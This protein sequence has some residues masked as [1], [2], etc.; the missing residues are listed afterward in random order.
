MSGERWTVGVIT[1]EY[2]DSAVFCH[3]RIVFTQHLLSINLNDEKT[4]TKEALNIGNTRP[5]PR[6]HA[7]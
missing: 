7:G 1:C 4:L 3:V 2:V 5:D 6:R